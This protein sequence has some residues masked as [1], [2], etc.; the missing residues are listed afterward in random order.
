MHVNN[1]DRLAAVPGLG[2]CI[3]IGEIQAGIPMGKSKVGT[4]IVMRHRSPLIEP[5]NDRIDTLV[6]IGRALRNA[7]RTRYT[8]AITPEA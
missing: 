7:L 8:V 2:K 1:E 5:V 3:Q 6:H 4:G